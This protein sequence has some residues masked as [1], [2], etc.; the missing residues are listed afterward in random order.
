MSLDYSGA[1]LQAELH[2][3]A[4]LQ[5]SKYSGSVSGMRHAL[6]LIGLLA[7]LLLAQQ[8]AV[9]HELSHVFGAAHSAGSNIDTRGTDT[10]CAQ[11][12]AFAQATA[13]AFSHSFQI[14]LHVLL[15]VQLA[16]ELTVAAIEA[17]LP[18]PRSRGPP[19]LS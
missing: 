11:C 15:T 7:V 1:A 3:R 9:I 12:P 13:A 19:A 2:R 8:G 6:K 14:P 5:N 4:M 18:D 17:A 16:S 10:A